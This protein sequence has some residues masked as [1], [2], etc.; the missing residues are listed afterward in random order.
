MRWNN[1][2]KDI[3]SFGILFVG[4]LNLSDK[5]RVAN[6]LTGCNIDFF[7]CR[8]NVNVMTLNGLEDNTL[9]RLAQY[10]EVPIPACPAQG[11]FQLSFR[12]SASGTISWTTVSVGRIGK[13]D[14]VP[15]QVRLEPSES[16]AEVSDLKWIVACLEQHVQGTCFQKVL[17]T[18]ENQDSAACLQF[19][20]PQAIEKQLP[21]Q[22]D[23][24]ARPICVDHPVAFSLPLSISRR[25]LK[26]RTSLIIGK[27]R[28]VGPPRSEKADKTRCRTAQSLLTLF[29]ASICS[30]MVTFC[31]KESGFWR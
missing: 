19:L 9:L 11:G 30:D 7:F 18:F 5:A 13:C 1:D 15:A 2:F 20:V 16:E 14:Y 17:C 10:A 31:P 21:L 8:V 26:S 12:L 6:F 24:G 23:A 27:R 28:R 22:L 29:V 4:H 25:P 3:L